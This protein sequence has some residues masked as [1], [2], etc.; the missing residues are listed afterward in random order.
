MN[1]ARSSPGQDYPVG[2]VVC[3]VTW[4]EQE[5]R[6]WFGAK[7]PGRVKSVEFAS[8]TAD[9]A[10]GKSVSLDSYTG[11]PLAKMPPP[12]ANGAAQLLSLR[13]AVIP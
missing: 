1:Y 9:P 7:I 13:A 5:D 3:L 2:A 10:G 4:E 6:R 12:D 11:S 8:V